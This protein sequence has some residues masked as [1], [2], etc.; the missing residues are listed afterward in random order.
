[1]FLEGLPLNILFFHLDTF[2]NL[3]HCKAEE[4]TGYY[5][6][7]EATISSELKYY[8]PLASSSTL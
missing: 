5:W 7:F 2:S 6:L 1:M 8:T 4:G 3:L